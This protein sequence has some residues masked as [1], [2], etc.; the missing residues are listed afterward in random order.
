MNVLYYFGALEW[1]GSVKVPLQVQ[2][3]TTECSNDVPQHRR[4]PKI[5][6]SKPK[7]HIQLRSWSLRSNPQTPIPKT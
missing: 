1:D 4:C 5:K 2:H 6:P 7:N 3:I